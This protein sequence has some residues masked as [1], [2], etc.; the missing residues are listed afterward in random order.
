MDERA[1]TALLAKQEITEAIYRYCRAMDRID[2][3]LGYSVWHD[4]AVADYGAMFQGTGHG[5]IDFVHTAH[6]QLPVHSHQVA[7][8]LIEVDGDQATSESYVT[9]TFSLADD[10]GVMR[11]ASSTG[12]YIDRWAKR[13]GRWAIAHRRYVHDFDEGWVSGGLL[14]PTQGRVDQGD[15]S[16]DI[17]TQTPGARAK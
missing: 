16:Y 13:D 3:A 12:R 9:A 17:L 6:Q 2:D 10:Q 5:F 15:P 11:V 4:D 14:Y 1:L 8:I 7:N